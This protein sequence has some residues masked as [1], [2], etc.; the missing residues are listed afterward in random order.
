MIKTNIKLPFSYKSADIRDAIVASLPVSADE[1]GEIRIIKR[2]LNLSDKTNI[3]YDVSVGVSF[4]EEREAGL[5]KMKKKVSQCP[6]MPFNVKPRR[7]RSRPVVIGAGPAGLFSALLFAESGCRPILIERGHDVDERTRLVDSFRR[8]GILDTECNIQ[9]GEGGA[10][11]YSDGKL[12]VGAPDKYKMKILREFVEQGAPEDILYSVGAHVGTDK[13]AKIVKKIREKIISLGGEVLFSTRLT[14]IT[15]RNGKLCSCTISHCGREEMIE[16]DTVVLA[17]GHSARDGFELLKRIGA[18]LEP[19]GFGIGVRIEH[20]REYIDK[21]VYGSDIPD[22]LGAAS[23]HL[24]T[25]LPG[26]RSVY[27]FCMCPGGEVVPATSE[28][29]CVVTNGMSEYA[30]ASDNSNAAFLVSLTPE[31]FGSDDALAGIELQRK[32][33]RAAFS[34]GGGSYTAPITTMSAFM[35]KEKISLGDVRPSYPMATREASPEEYLPSYVTESLSLAIPAFDAWM[36]GFYTPDAVITGAETRSTSPI[37][38]LRDERYSAYGIHG[39]YPVGEGAGYSGGI[40]SS[41]RDALVV[42][43]SILENAEYDK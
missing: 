17:I 27:S 38:V 25:H 35:K 5:L 29:G 10:G 22:G 15:V 6:N 1:I 31:D 7:M 18:R 4:S 13:L 20:K 32:I 2:S 26:G 39:L 41:A 21:L 23:Y 37:R 8:F 33:E 16:T 28:E 3:H 24:V 30:R 42:T 36:P 12:K 9:F 14:D 40:I 19:R 34:A 11:T 43:E